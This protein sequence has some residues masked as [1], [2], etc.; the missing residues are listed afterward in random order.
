MRISN[1]KTFLILALLPAAASAAGVPAPA[2]CVMPYSPEL[3]IKCYTSIIN[4]F[5]GDEPSD[6]KALMYRYRALVYVNIKKPEKALFDYTKAIALDTGS[7]QSPNA[8]ARLVCERAG[9]HGKLGNARKAIAD[10]RACAAAGNAWAEEGIGE[11]LM[12]LGDLSGAINHLSRAIDLGQRYGYVYRN[13][14][15][16]YRKAGKN[17][18]AAADAEKAVK[19]DPADTDALYLRVK[20]RLNSGNA[21]GALEDLA[22]LEELTGANNE[23]A[24]YRG[25]ANYMIGSKALAEKFFREVLDARVDSNEAMLN[26]A[27]YWWG[28]NRDAAKARETLEKYGSPKGAPTVTGALAECLKGI[29]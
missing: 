7:P 11:T 25:L 10:Y 15:E 19:L 13:R 29:P 27:C 9:V 8:K 1:L 22:R 17:I 21:R 2:D 26:L 4:S 24:S 28:I 6:H 5:S 20:T 12:E 18:K 14:A 23:Y 16:A 3:S